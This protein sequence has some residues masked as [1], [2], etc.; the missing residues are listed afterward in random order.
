MKF[1]FFYA[2]LISLFFGNKAMTQDYY[3]P[4]RPNHITEASYNFY[5]QNLDRAYKTNDFREIGIALANMGEKKQRVYA[6]LNLSVEKKSSECYYF[7]NLNRLYKEDNFET[8]MTKLSVRDWEILCDRCSTLMK[9]EEYQRLRQER[10]DAYRNKIKIDSLKLDFSLIKQLDTIDE[11]DQRYRGELMK[12]L[13]DSQKKELWEKQTQLDKE[14]LIA[15]EKIF[16]K[17]GYPG[18]SLVG[19]KHSSTAFM[20]IHHY[21]D[22]KIKEKYLPFLEEAVKKKKLSD[23]DLAALKHRIKLYYLEKKTDT[24]K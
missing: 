5:K 24:P 6:Y 15:I 16:E 10:I 13:T 19:V 9:I 12:Q 21:P 7:H 1:S 23:G 22:I 4:V 2:I 8:V 3:Y 20:V 18:F 11:K 14:N 17:Y